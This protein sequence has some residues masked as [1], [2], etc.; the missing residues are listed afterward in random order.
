MMV[1]VIIVGYIID[2]RKKYDSKELSK[3]IRVR[4]SSMNIGGGQELY[5]PIW[6]WQTRKKR[7]LGN[8]LRKK[9][10]TN[11]YYPKNIL[12]KPRSTRFPLRR[13]VWVILT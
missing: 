2:K 7:L 8:L 3:K 11:Y 13:E 1:I 10:S 6:I 9:A 5:A 12:T 4:T